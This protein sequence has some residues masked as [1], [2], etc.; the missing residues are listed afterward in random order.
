MTILYFGS[1]LVRKNPF[2]ISSFSAPEVTVSNESDDSGDFVYSDSG[3]GY[4]SRSSSSKDPLLIHPSQ[5]S[6]SVLYEDP[7]FTR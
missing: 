5:T 4:D 1:L 6:N 7:P 3:D 2:F